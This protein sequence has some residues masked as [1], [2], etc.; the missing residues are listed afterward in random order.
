MLCDTLASFVAGSEDLPGTP[1]SVAGYRKRMAILARA[2]E[3]APRFVLDRAAVSMLSDLQHLEPQALVAALPLCRMPFPEIWVEFA[4]V[5]RDDWLRDNLKY[6]FPFHRCGWLFREA[7]EDST[8]I[9]G[10]LCFTER[11][12][13][14]RDLPFIT[15]LRLI[16]DSGEPTTSL[17]E[18]SN[19]FISHIETET[20]KKYTDAERELTTHISGGVHETDVEYMD[21]LDK[22]DDNYLLRE[23]EDRGRHIIGTERT[24]IIALLVAMNSRNLFSL[25]ENEPNVKLNRNRARVGKLPFMSY[26]S[27]TLNLSTSQKR[28]FAAARNANKLK[29]SHVVRGHFKIR[30]SGIYWWSPFIRGGDEAITARTYKVTNKPAT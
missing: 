23:A 17:I 8:V 1:E 24:F 25:S 29:T 30:K 10:H 26:K 13:S 7:D 14:M 4:G 2:V 28:R 21:S 3:K 11:E 22:H 15:V 12:N 27:V 5:D 16:F 20:H 6:N 18:H 9:V 19:S